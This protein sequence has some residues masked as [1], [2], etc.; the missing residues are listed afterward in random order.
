MAGCASAAR[1]PAHA[2]YG[3]PSAPRLIRSWL[4]R[5]E[6]TWTSL[7]LGVATPASSTSPRSRAA[8]RSVVALRDRAPLLQPRDRLPVVAELEEDLLGVL[9][10]LRHRPLRRPAVDGEVDGRGDTWDLC[11]VGLRDVDEGAGGDRLRVADDVLGRLHGRPPHAGAVEDRAP[12][13]ERAGGEDLVEQ[14]NQLGAVLAPGP[15]GREARI[16]EPVGTLDGAQQ[17]GPVA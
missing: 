12:L 13:G 16:L 17:V 8:S 9:P 4:G 3:A 10:D 6:Y 11:P 2:A 5:R 1:Q 15:H 7:P 14:L